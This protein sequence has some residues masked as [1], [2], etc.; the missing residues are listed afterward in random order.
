MGFLRTRSVRSK[1]PCHSHGY[2]LS[3]G[4]RHHSGQGGILPAFRDTILPLHL[5]CRYQSNLSQMSILSLHSLS[6]SPWMSAYGLQDHMQTL[7]AARPFILSLPHSQTVTHACTHLWWWPDTT[8]VPQVYWACVTSSCLVPTIP[9]TWKV[10]ASSCPNAE[11]LLTRPK[12]LE[13]HPSMLPS[14]LHSLWF[15]T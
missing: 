14:G 2:C 12:P 10:G 8:A 1:L 6:E 11:F 3:S 9:S 7:W 4:L 15:S 5:L 13:P